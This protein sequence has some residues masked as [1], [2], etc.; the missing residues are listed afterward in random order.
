MPAV[1]SLPNTLHLKVDL[2]HIGE[3]WLWCT[4]SWRSIDAVW[5]RRKDFLER[6]TLLSDLA[7]SDAHATDP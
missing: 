4:E 5:R 1:I 7:L 2:S 6:D 3:K